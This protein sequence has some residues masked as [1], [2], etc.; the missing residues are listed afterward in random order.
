M[1]NLNGFKNV[2]SPVTNELM[3]N[4]T[5]SYANFYISYARYLPHYGCDTTALV[6]GDRVF[7][8]LNGNHANEMKNLAEEKGIGGVI[9]YFITNI[10][11]ANSWSEHKMA[12]GLSPDPFGLHDTA[13]K[14]LGQTIIDRIVKTL[15][16]QL[17]AR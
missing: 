13:L 2:R 3:P 15:I 9:E 7:F 14:I 8:I 16:N 10:N 12:V 1:K 17:K 11:Q 6:L 4:M 5:R